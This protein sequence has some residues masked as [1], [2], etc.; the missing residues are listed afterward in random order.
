[1]LSGLGEI[2][3]FTSEEIAWMKG[4]LR[5]AEARYYQNLATYNDIAGNP[6]NLVLETQRDA[7][8]RAKALVDK[9][10]RNLQQ[11]RSSMSSVIESGDTARLRAWFDLSNTI[12]DP[13]AVRIF[14]EQI[15]F[16]RTT[17]TG[18]NVG[19][20]TAKDLADPS[21]W[22]AWIRPVLFVGGALVALEVFKVFGRRS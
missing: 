3:A 17:Q 18:K 10:G 5:M 1:M 15:D 22:P 20:Q 14:H 2:R 13:N 4:S 11:L 12:I 8:R 19:A 21:K 7:L 16:A 6:L 9:D